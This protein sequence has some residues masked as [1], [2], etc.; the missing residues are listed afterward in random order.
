MG[1]PQTPTAP[2]IC[3]WCGSAFTR[4]RRPSGAMESIPNFQRRRFCRQSCATRSQFAGYESRIDPAA[5][6][7]R[8]DKS[9]D[10]WEWS[11]ARNEQRGGYGMLNLR[12]GNRKSPLG[13]HRIA[14]EL[15][16]GQIPVGLFVC[17]HCDNPPCVRP[18]H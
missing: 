13:A 12:R 10:C 4:K 9:G 16:Y 3:E 8:V 2:R 18:E 7:A 14:W 6:W 11:G 17:H 15:T 1:P 5:F